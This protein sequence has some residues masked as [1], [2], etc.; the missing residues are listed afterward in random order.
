MNRC[1]PPA[2]D[3]RI[4]S[5]CIQSD[6]GSFSAQFDSAIRT[7]FLFPRYSK[8]SSQVQSKI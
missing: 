1:R 8:Y 3:V 5:A 7:A 4:R 2:Q 6:S